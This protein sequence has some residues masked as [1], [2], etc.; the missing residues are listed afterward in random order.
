MPNDIGEIIEELTDK[1]G[2]KSKKRNEKTFVL[3]NYLLKTEKNERQRIA[4]VADKEGNLLYF[5]V[6]FPEQ[7]EYKRIWTNKSSFGK[8]FDTVKK[9][10]YYG[11][12]QKEPINE[13]KQIALL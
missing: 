7:N 8:W 5:G 2:K 12:N 9:F 3:G 10:Y 4:K 1:F 13:E 6:K 11:Q